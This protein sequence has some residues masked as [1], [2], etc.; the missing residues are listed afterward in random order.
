MTNF[1]ACRDHLEAEELKIIDKLRALADQ[2]NIGIRHN[3]QTGGK[4]GKKLALE[5]R[6]HFIK[7]PPCLA[8]VVNFHPEAPYERG[9]WGF[10]TL[11][12]K[13]ESIAEESELVL[14]RGELVRPPIG[15]V[16]YLDPGFNEAV[17]RLNVVFRGSMNFQNCGITAPWKPTRENPQK[18]SYIL[19]PWY[20]DFPGPDP[21]EPIDRALRHWIFDPNRDKYEW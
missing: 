6:L 10:E 17:G 16:A 5:P 2:N 8:L 7:K 19:F 15:K 1:S 14:A 21:E 18:L 13:L 11:N 20:P 12:Q 9:G 3:P 4:I